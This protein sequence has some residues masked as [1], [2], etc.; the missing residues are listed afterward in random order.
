MKKLFYFLPLLFLGLTFNSCG[1]DD[2]DYDTGMVRTY[3]YTGQE[4]S[5]NL[6]FRW[7]GNYD[8]DW[9]SKRVAQL[10]INGDKASVRGITKGSI[11]KEI[12]DTGGHTIALDIKVFNTDEVK[13]TRTTVT[14][15][16]GQKV[17]GCQ[18]IEYSKDV[19][20]SV[21]SADETIVSAEISDDNVNVTAHKA[22]ITTITVSTDNGL[23]TVVEIR[24]NEKN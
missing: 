18:I 21:A 6:P 3:L 12:Y 19:K 4:I 24:V 13:L 16:I 10:T 11:L 2:N 14:P 1:G 20:Y 15:P 23:S 8:Q 9:E 17:I 22:G 7:E 5:V